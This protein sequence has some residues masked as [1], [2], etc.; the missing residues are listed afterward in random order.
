MVSPSCHFRFSSVGTWLVLL[1]RGMSR[2]P[3]SFVYSIH[4]GGQFETSV[5]NHSVLGATGL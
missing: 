2:Y 3:L 5:M 1:G 4:P